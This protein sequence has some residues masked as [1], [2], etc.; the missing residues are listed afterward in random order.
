MDTAEDLAAILNKGDNF[1]DFLFSF[2]HTSPLLK[3]SLLYKERICSLGSKLF[4]YRREDAFKKGT[5]TLFDS[6]LLWILIYS[7]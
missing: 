6:Y 5:N 1:C 7:P 2:L 4:P 3:R